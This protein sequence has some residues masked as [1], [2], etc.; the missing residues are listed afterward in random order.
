M[1]EEEMEKQATCIV[2]KEETVLEK[3]F[4]RGYLELPH[5][6]FSAEDRKRAGEMLAGDF[7]RGQYKNIRALQIYAD[8]IPTTG[9]WD[10][11]FAIYY[12]EKYFAAVKSIPREFWPSVRRVCIEDKMLKCEAEVSGSRLKNKNSI[13][14]QKM[15]LNMG[16]ERLV[17]H[18]LKKNKKSS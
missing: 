15:L 6:R 9:T 14:F 4:K 1:R 16:L 3:Y 2:K 11:D 13:Y 7:Y 10:E 5:S 17:E 8:H 18:Y 12:R